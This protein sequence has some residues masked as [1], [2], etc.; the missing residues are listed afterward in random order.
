MKGDAACFLRSAKNRTAALAGLAVVLFAAAGPA[1]AQKSPA[2][3]CTGGEIAVV[4]LSTLTVSGSRAGYDKAVNDQLAWYRAHGFKTNR[5]VTAP[6][7]TQDANTK[8]W[9]VSQTEILSLHINPP[10]IDAVKA[11]EAFKAFVAE[12]RQN[13]VVASERT[14]CLREALK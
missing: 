11:D 10:P 14:I 5:L 4:R 13:S 6:V 3:F 8:E 9:A 1:S 2:D 12:F 7:I